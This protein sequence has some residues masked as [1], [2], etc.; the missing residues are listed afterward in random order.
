MFSELVKLFRKSGKLN[1]TGI[2][3]DV[4]CITLTTEEKSEMDVTET[5][6][7]VASP[8]CFDMSTFMVNHFNIVNN[9]ENIFVIKHKAKAYSDEL[10]HSN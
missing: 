4:H 9:F 3:Q 6:E 10:T 8:G 2:T 5:L 7:F 1:A